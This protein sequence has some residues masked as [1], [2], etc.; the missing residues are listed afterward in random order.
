MTYV[1][2]EL[3]R[4]W[5]QRP[6]SAEG[7]LPGRQE[8]AELLLGLLP[9]SAALEQMRLALARQAPGR[10]VSRMDD[11]QVIT[12]YTEIMLHDPL[13]TGGV[14]LAASASGAGGTAPEEPAAV[15]ADTTPVSTRPRPGPQV[16]PARAPSAPAATSAARIADAMEA[17]LGKS[18]WLI[19]SGP[20]PNYSAFARWAGAGTEGPPPKFDKE[21]KFNC[22]ESI[23][24]FAHQNGAVTWK[25]MHD[26][27]ASGWV[28]DFENLS[29]AD[30]ARTDRWFKAL[31]DRLSKG[32]RAT[33]VPGKTAPARGDMVFFNGPAHVAMATGK[34]APDGSPEVLTFG[35]GRQGHEVSSS[36]VEK[37]GEH[38]PEDD[39]MEVTF[40]RPYWAE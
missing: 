21:H 14:V 15:E 37:L 23:L 32:G 20:F 25:Q 5:R 1:R 40:A 30:E 16:E 4:R 8:V 2:D 39:C 7:V 19:M 35:M 22:W 28:E 24:I 12:G 29:E 18:A 34:M 3:K 38:F 9:H 36:S 13:V 27:Y 17:G 10:P 31:P 6:E 33:Y 26:L 11:Q